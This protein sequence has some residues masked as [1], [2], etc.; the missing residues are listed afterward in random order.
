MT[1]RNTIQLV[2]PLEVHVRNGSGPYKPCLP[3]RE[4]QNGTRLVTIDVFV[5]VFETRRM[6]LL[7]DV[8]DVNAALRRPG[9]PFF[10]APPEARL[11]GCA[12]CWSRWVLSRFFCWPF[13]R[14]GQT[15]WWFGL[16]VEFCRLFVGKAGKTGGKREGN[17]A[18]QASF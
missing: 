11:G 5:Q 2:V 13:L 12:A 16:G 1:P 15:K 3:P 9:A 14:S 8:K 18:L 10:R 7:R 17:G 4:S 6:E